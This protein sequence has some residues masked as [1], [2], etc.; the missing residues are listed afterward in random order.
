MR[1][2]PG[3][4]LWRAVWPYLPAPILNLT[5]YTPTPLYR[6]LRKLNAMFEDI[7]RPLYKMNAQ[8]WDSSREGKRDALS[9]LSEFPSSRSHRVL[10]LTDCYIHCI[11][12]KANTSESARVRLTESEVLAQMHHLTAAGHETTSNTLTWMLYEL[13]QRPEY[14]ARMREE[15]RAARAQVV[16]RGDSAFTMDDLDG[17]KVVLAVIKVSYVRCRPSVLLN[18]SH[19]GDA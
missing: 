11:L 7:G 17:M 10:S 14:Q 5:K 19:A 16:S 4:L 15:I 8:E 6:R 18:T 9:V 1:P 2:T 12:V 13:A 3:M